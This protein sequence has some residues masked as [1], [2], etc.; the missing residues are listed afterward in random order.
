MT[1]L[2]KEEIL[3][4][5]SVLS[6][7]LNPLHVFVL[8]CFKEISKTFSTVFAMPNESAVWHKV[9]DQIHDASSFQSAKLTLLAEYLIMWS[10]LNI[11]INISKAKLKERMLCI[12]GDNAGLELLIYSYSYICYISIL[13][14]NETHIISH[15]PALAA[16]FIPVSKEK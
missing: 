3:H 16:C 9:Q 1:Y 14:V 13:N 7:V 6:A 12:V 10:V 5:V 11:A 8:I 15:T 2:H 4:C